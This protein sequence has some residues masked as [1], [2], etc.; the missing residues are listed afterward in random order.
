LKVKTTRTIHLDFRS[1]LVS[2]HAPLFT[3]RR[4]QGGTT[5][6]TVGWV[7]DTALSTPPQTSMSVLADS[8]SAAQTVG[9]LQ[10]SGQVL[11]WRGTIDLND[12]LRASAG[13]MPD[14]PGMDGPPRG[15]DA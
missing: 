2:H 9:E 3:V 4:H 10:A 13:G 15:M 1:R 14:R 5:S 12:A 11:R 8:T 6:P 7:F